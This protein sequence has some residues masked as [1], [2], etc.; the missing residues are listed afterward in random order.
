MSLKPGQLIG[1]DKQIIWLNFEKQN[2][3][4]FSGV[5]VLWKFG[6]FNIS[7][8]FWAGDLKLGQLI[9]YDEQMTWVTF[10]RILSIYIEL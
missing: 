4:K 3:S 10:E 8:T 2:P 9:G 6:Y 1:D 5:M 7:K